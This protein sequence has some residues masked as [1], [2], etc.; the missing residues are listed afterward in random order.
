MPHCWKTYVAAHL[1]LL[2][3]FIRVCLIPGFVVKFLLTFLDW[4][5]VSCLG[6]VSFR[7][8][9]DLQN[10]RKKQTQFHTNKICTC[11]VNFHD[12]MFA[13]VTF[14]KVNTIRVLKQFRSRSGRSVG[15]EL[16]QNYWQGL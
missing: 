14:Q 3:L 5:P 11:W 13:K 15:P 6:N 4:R 16:G 2:S 7:I 1:L 9:E 12:L 8:S 10:W